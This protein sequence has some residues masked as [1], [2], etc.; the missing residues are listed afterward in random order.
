MFSFD[1][2]FRISVLMTSLLSFTALAAC[3]AVHPA[4]IVAG[5]AVIALSAFKGRLPWSPSS[6]LWLVFTALALLA[7]AAEAFRTMT[8]GLLYFVIWL[9]VVKIWNPQ[10]NRDYGWAF[11]ICF[12]EVVFATL[13]TDRKSVV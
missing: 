4:V 6:R 8:M 12:F 7:C 13:F 2:V 1:R 9:Q 3:G 10:S 11:V 5:Y